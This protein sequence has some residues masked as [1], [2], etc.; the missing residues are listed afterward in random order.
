M[1][2]SEPWMRIY[3]ESVNSRYLPGYFKHLDDECVRRLREEDLETIK[4]YSKKK[5]IKR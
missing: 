5:S 4:I 2:I 3:G 1:A